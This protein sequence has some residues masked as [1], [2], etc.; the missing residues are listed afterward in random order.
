MDNLNRTT[1]DSHLPVLFFFAVAPGLMKNTLQRTSRLTSMLKCRNEYRRARHDIAVD[2]A[3]IFAEIMTQGTTH[4][5]FNVVQ[6]LHKRALS[7]VTP[8]AAVV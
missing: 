3:G 5:H 4:K 8:R 7:P 6:A 1:H 2:P